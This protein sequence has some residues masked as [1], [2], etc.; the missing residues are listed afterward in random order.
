MRSK[1]VYFATGA[2]STQSHDSLD[3]WTAVMNRINGIALDVTFMVRYRSSPHTQ[4]SVSVRADAICM[5]EF[6]TNYPSKVCWRVNK[7][8]WCE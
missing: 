8:T 1:K 2:I 3:G 5:H 6:N 7:R 4:T